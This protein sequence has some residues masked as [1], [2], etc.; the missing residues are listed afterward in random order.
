MGECDELE[1]LVSRRS[2]AIFQPGL[3]F[4]RGFALDEI[5][6]GFDSVLLTETTTPRRAIQ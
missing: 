6:V 3:I 4:S 5:S 2:I 1:L